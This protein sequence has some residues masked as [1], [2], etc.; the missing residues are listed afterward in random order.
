MLQI[1]RFQIT[2]MTPRRRALPPTT[3]CAS[4]PVSHLVSAS[5][6]AFSAGLLTLTIQ[7]NARPSLCSL[8]A[9]MPQPR[10]MP[11]LWPCLYVVSTIRAY[12]ST[13]G[14]AAGSQLRWSW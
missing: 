9:P 13:P 11:P 5:P 3:P 7:S 12:A 8:V 10:T 4:L 6:A 14:L 1:R 2:Y